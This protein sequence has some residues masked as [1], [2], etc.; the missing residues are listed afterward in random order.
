MR[1]SY[2]LL[3]G[4]RKLLH[5]QDMFEIQKFRSQ[6]KYLPFRTN[7]ARILRS[8]GYVVIFLALCSNNNNEREPY[9][10]R[11]SSLPRTSPRNAKVETIQDCLT[12]SLSSCG[13][14][15]RILACR[16]R[17]SCLQVR[18]LRDDQYVQSM[19]LVEHDR[20]HTSLP[21]RDRLLGGLT[22]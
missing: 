2:R 6:S 13:P 22:K 8:L 7:I 9:S 12:A 10:V 1:I 21:L 19:V 16:I 11:V 14:K 5:V 3:R 15:K 20:C 4:S 17:S 18:Y